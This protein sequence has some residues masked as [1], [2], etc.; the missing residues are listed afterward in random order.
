MQP[1]S[2]AH[3]AAHGT[4]CCDG[5]KGWMSEICCQMS[6]FMYRNTKYAFYLL[7]AFLLPNA[8]YRYF[9]KF[10]NYPWNSLSVFIQMS[11]TM[12]CV[13]MATWSHW[14]ASKPSD[15]GYVGWENFRT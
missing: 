8:F 12:F 13:V 3:D 6:S 2:H 1:A 7:M 15:P 5:S 4:K 9:F 10:G 11:I 14:I